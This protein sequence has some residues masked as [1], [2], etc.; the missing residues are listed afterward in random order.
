MGYIVG[1]DYGLKN[2]GVAVG[3]TITATASEKPSFSAR[4]G[5]PDWHKVEQF[6]N[7]WK[8]QE[9]VVGLP[10]NMDDTESELSAR[11]R[12][13]ANRLHGRFGIKV[14][15]MDERL[16]TREAKAEAS[17]RGHKGDYGNNPIDGIAARLI[18]ESWLSNQ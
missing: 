11:A 18:L 1:F 7:E 3:Q 8:I 12:K 16:S 17:E 5:I 6:L 14:H 2:I 9:A 10:L 4:D 13:F 15:L